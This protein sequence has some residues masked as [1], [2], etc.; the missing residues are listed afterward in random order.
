MMLLMGIKMS[1][2]KNPTNPIT[3]NPIAV[4][5]ATFVN[6]TTNNQKKGNTESN[7]DLSPP[8]KF[9]HRSS[10]PQTIHIDPADQTVEKTQ[11]AHNN[12]LKDKNFELK[13]KIR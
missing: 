9:T 6:S 7:T 3:T 10:H 12:Y 5:T 11:I 8:F 2:T 1:F 13:C 4:R